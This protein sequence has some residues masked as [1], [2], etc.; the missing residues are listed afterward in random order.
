[1]NLQDELKGP[2][3][4]SLWDFLSEQR[5]HQQCL[6]GLACLSGPLATPVAGQEGAVA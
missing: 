4:T 6:W 3:V 2:A 1:M 5:W